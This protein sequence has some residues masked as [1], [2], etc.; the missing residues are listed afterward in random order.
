MGLNVLPISMT[1]LCAMWCLYVH[2]RWE[3]RQEKQWDDASSA[4]V[5][6]ILIISSVAVADVVGVNQHQHHQL[7]LG[8]MV[9]LSLWSLTTNT[10]SCCSSSWTLRWRSSRTQELDWRRWKSLCGESI[11]VWGCSESHQVL[12]NTH[13]CFIYIYTYVYLFIIIIYYY[14]NYTFI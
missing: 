10:W 4:Y 1:C 12:D 8:R 13:V 9:F 7:P 5:W 14:Y 3:S 11:A 6:A 2:V